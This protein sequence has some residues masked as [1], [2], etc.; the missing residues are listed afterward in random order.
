MIGKRLKKKYNVE[1]ER[2]AIHDAVAHWMGGVRE[3]G[4][5]FL[6]GREE[7][8]VADLSVYGVLKAI[9]TF[10]TFAEI[11][12]RNE[13]FAQWFDRMKLVVGDSHETKVE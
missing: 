9:Q 8:G 2:E 5:K 1:D 7:P 13:E 6:D 3:G 4:G 10:D 11:R 12:S